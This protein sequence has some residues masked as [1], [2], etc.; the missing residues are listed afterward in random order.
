MIEV[1]RH[2]SIAL[3]LIVAAAAALPS[4]ASAA[5]VQYERDD[6]SVE[7]TA[8]GELAGAPFRFGT[9]RIP[10]L[11]AGDALAGVEGA[12]G[13]VMTV[14]PG[15]GSVGG[16]VVEVLDHP[17]AAPVANAIIGP[18]ALLPDEE[19]LFVD[20][21][22]GRLDPPSKTLRSAFGSLGPAFTYSGL[23]ADFRLAEG[24]AGASA[25]GAALGGE[26]ERFA[27]TPAVGGEERLPYA[28]AA[29]GDA[30]GSAA[31]A[32]GGGVA[33]HSARAGAVGGEAGFDRARAVV[34]AAAVVTPLALIGWALYHRIRGHS[35]LDNAT[36]KQIFD[37]V[38]ARPGI[39]VQEVAEV[40][41]VSYSTASYH[42]ERLCEARIL[43]LSV[44]GS[45]LRYYQN[46]GAFTEADR[47]LLPLLKN[48]EAMRVLGAI[49]ETPGT[50]RAALAERLGVTATTINWHLKR[51]AEAGLI[52]ETRQGRSAFLSVD[53]ERLATAVT[54]LLPKLEA[55]EAQTAEFARR[56]LG[57]A[58][59]AGPA[60]AASPP[61]AA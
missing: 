26:T 2:D 3:V 52:Q 60:E 30:S 21:V 25:A 34:A 47:K 11:K 16:V 8:E 29:P 20:P 18:L 22:T 13:A 35:T 32:A 27:F 43:V 12:V 38:V 48:A 53:R 59:P 58:A 39:G 40:A 37:A 7:A 42:L 41:N 23:T 6:E 17:G 19:S 55:H 4:L 50:Y 61:V 14:L 9:G 57:V 56:M 46:G 54:P 44:E 49:L 33:A 28:P 51:L 10:L 45:K 36:R 5:T 31:P 24:V 1:R 15:D